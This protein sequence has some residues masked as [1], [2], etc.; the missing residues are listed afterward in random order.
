MKFLKEITNIDKKLFKEATLYGVL[1][2]AVTYAISFVLTLLYTTLGATVQSV[3]AEQ[4]AK[5]AY[6]AMFMLVVSIILFLLDYAFFEY[7][8]W[9]IIYKKKTK[10]NNVVKFSGLIV[11][12]M[13]IFGAING[14]IFFII[15]KFPD[16]VVKLGVS[17]FFLGVLLSLYLMYIGFISFTQHQKIGIA[18][19]QTFSIGIGKLGVTIYP[20]VISVVVGAIVNII[21]YLFN[22]LPQPVLY[23]L[24]GVA[25]AAYLAWFRIY[26]ANSLKSVKF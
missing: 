20:L 25:F 13:A 22:W 21:L 6:F 17:I 1:F 24:Q 4:G 2:F 12:L 5:I 23:A 14:I 9:N 7:L 15:S 3:G 19:K 18:I 11:S 8:I 26:L 10:F 16:S